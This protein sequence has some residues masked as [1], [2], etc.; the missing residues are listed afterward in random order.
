MHWLFLVLAV[1]FENA[2]TISMKLSQGFRNTL[3]SVL[4]PVCYLPSFF[5]LTMALKRI[6]VSVAYAVWSG[7]GTLCIAMVGFLWF[8]KN[9]SLLRLLSICMIVAGVAGLNLSG[10]TSSMNG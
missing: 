7:L 6:D 4:I 8:R 3:P 9:L 10:A 2:G 1:L 5:F